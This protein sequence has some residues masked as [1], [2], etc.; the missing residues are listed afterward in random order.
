M[1]TYAATTLATI[2]LASAISAVAQQNPGNGAAVG[3]AMM[4]ILSST[5]SETAA[6]LSPTEKAIVDKARFDVVAIHPIKNNDL[7]HISI[8]IHR[9]DNG[10][11]GASGFTMRMLLSLTLGFDETR[12]KGGPEWLDDDR[13]TIA[14]KPDE[15][16]SKQIEGLSEIG[17][18]YVY[19][20]MIMEMLTERLELKSHWTSEQQTVLALE[21]AKGGSK[22]KDSTVKTGHSSMST[23]NGTLTAS[24]T[25]MK[26]LATFLTNQLHQVV[27][28]QTGLEGFYDFSLNWDPET[29]DATT[30]DKPAL[31][32][33]VQEQ[34]GLKLSSRKAPVDILVIDTIHR[35]SEN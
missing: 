9:A 6:T 20:K 23:G 8:S 3:A 12:I 26:G 15:E 30:S 18:K 25:N 14:A 24:H 4:G 22:L 35:P 28:D 32:T 16:L 34:L 10:D 27:Q 29:G 19:K 5:Q 1:H 7:Q 13:F 17:R 21:I 31:P 33:A 11:F 2:F